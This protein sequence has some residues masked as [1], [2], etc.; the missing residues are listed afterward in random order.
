[1]AITIEMRPE[2]SIEWAYSPRDPEKDKRGNLQFRDQYIQTASGEIIVQKNN[3]E[4]AFFMLNKCLHTT[5]HKDW[6]LV[7]EK[8]VATISVEKKR[9]KVESDYYVNSL[10]NDTELRLL[11]R[12]FCQIMTPIEKM[13]E[14]QVRD[15]ID[16]KLNL[17]SA[18]YPDVYKDF[19][20]SAKN[21]G[22]VEVKAAI[23][24][25]LSNKIIEIDYER[26]F[27]SYRGDKTPIYTF[28]F[29]DFGHEIDALARY[30]ENEGYSFYKNLCISLGIATEN[31]FDLKEKNPGMFNKAVKDYAKKVGIKTGGKTNEKL[32]QEVTEHWNNSHGVSVQD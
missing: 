28:A 30:S 2:G 16:K 13:T 12:G 14:D 10:L 6:Y 25:A 27:V 22:S 29:E 1:M 19:V 5:V 24:K 15:M 23:V 4:L 26:H 21:S 32:E 31:F 8:K 17:M 7:D 20:L 18:N 11:A 9:A 3:P